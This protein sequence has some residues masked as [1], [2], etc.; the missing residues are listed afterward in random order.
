MKNPET[1]L[2]NQNLKEKLLQNGENIHNTR[3]GSNYEYATPVK[4]YQKLKFDGLSK[5]NILAYGIGHFQND[6]TATTLLNYT[7]IFLKTIY[8]I[9]DLNPGYW[10]GFSL[11]VGQIVDGIATP[12]VGAFSDRI[13]TKIGKR[14]PW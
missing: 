9:N 3:R 10:L 5:F 12:L 14:I 2:T 1:Q 6:I 7:P 8:P 4:L 13:H 11:L